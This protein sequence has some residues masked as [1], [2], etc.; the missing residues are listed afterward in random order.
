MVYLQADSPTVAARTIRSVGVPSKSI[1]V[2][3]MRW[4]W[5]DVRSEPGVV[6]DLSSSGS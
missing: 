3:A 5:V 2:V 1:Q 6:P 4:G